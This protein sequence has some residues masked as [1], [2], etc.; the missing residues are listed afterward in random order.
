MAL[1]KVF[2]LQ[3]AGWKVDLIH[4][5]AGVHESVHATNIMIP[6]MFFEDG[7]NVNYAADIKKHVKT[8]VATVGALMTPD[9][10]EEI[11]ASGKADVVQVARGLLADPDL[12]GRRVSVRRMILT[13]VC[14]AICVF[15]P[16]PIAE[17][18]PALLILK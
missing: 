6:A 11:L 10:M 15:P 2:A 14:D 12:P 5:S 1:R 4:V 16:T 13:P 8:P 17:T 18:E 3:S 7:Y 9:Y